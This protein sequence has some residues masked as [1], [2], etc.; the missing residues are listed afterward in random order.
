MFQRKLLFPFSGQE[1]KIVGD[2]TVN[3]SE[4]ICSYHSYQYF[5]GLVLPYG[6]KLTLG[7]LALEVVPFH[8]YAPFP[9]LLPFFIC[10]L[11]SS[12]VGVFSAT[13]HSTLITSI[14]SKWWPSSF[15]FNQGNRDKKV[16]GG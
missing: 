5:L 11:E 15:I 2:K 13:C 3:N 4:H 1:E 9:V 6:Q 14:V 16:G 10:I 12:S 8:V 7:L